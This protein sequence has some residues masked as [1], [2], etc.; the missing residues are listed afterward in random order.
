MNKFFVLLFCTNII[1]I[2]SFGQSKYEL[3]GTVVDENK[4]PLPGA[5]VYLF[6]ISKGSITD[7]LGNFVIT[8]INTGMYRIMIS[9]MGYNSTIDTLKID[10]DIVFN[11][12]LSVSA[13]TLQ[14]VVVSDNYTET[15]K[16]EQSL[17]IEIVNDDYPKQTLG[18][19]LMQSP[20]RL[21]GVTTIDICSGQSKPVIRGLGF[22]RVV[23]VENNIKHE[24]QQWGADHGLEIDQ[25]AID[26]VEIIKGP[27]S[28]MYGSDA[29]GGVIDMKN[30]KLPADSSYGGS[31][32]LSGKTNNDFVGTSISLYVRKKWFFADFRATILDFGDY[33]VP[34]D[35]VDS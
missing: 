27:A 1:C 5:T 15:R 9:F 26:H 32:D 16:K 34:T 3:K 35:S 30:R 29:M 2:S 17:N 13:L 31:V 6:P 7:K 23:V 20:E 21:P 4:Q 14:E 19:S 8:G 10:R 11:A 28:L 24:A 18:G 12:Q 33:K 25:Y 22:N